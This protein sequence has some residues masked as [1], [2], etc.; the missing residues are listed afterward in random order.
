MH[1]ITYYIYVYYHIISLLYM[2]YTII[3]Y[4]IYIILYI[5]QVLGY[6][7]KTMQEKLYKLIY[8]FTGQWLGPGPITPYVPGYE[9]TESYINSLFAGYIIGEEEDSYIPFDSS[10]DGVSGVEGQNYDLSSDI[11]SGSS[12]PYVLID[13]THSSAT[14]TT[15]NDREMTIEIDM[16]TGT[17]LDIN[18]KEDLLPSSYTSSSYTSSYRSSSD[19]TYTETGE[20]DDS[21]SL[22]SASLFTSEGKSELFDVSTDDYSSDEE[23]DDAA[24]GESGGGSGISSEDMLFYDK[25]FSIQE[26]LSL[27]VLSE[28]IRGYDRKIQQSATATT[29]ATSTSTVGAHKVSSDTSTMLVQQNGMDPSSTIG[30]IPPVVPPV[31]ANRPRAPIDLKALG[32]DMLTYED[33]APMS[34]D[35]Y[36]QPGITSIRWILKSV[37]HLNLTINEVRKMVKTFPSILIYTPIRNLRTLWAVSMSLGANRKEVSRWVCFFPRLVLQC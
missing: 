37:S 35:D 14:L 24:G 15:D 21:I 26:V 3:Y 31:A 29:T 36:D 1:T 27:D 7:P 33:D 4:T 25:L 23:G 20:D 11:E 2:Y 9:S 10:S 32:T 5:T 28:V 34:I 13:D 19:S 18:L 12:E 22:S 30:V 6:N 8:L 16:N 17:L